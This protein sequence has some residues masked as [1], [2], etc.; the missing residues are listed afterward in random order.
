MGVKWENPCIIGSTR[1]RSGAAE[2]NSP[3]VVQ[4]GG[5][6]ALQHLLPGHATDH[7]DT[8]GHHPAQPADRLGPL[9]KPG[10][11]TRQGAGQVWD[12]AQLHLSPSWRRLSLTRLSLVAS[13]VVCV[14]RAQLLL[15]P[16]QRPLLCSPAQ[17][18][19]GRH[20]GKRELEMNTKLWPWIV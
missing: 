9:A 15:L 14:V 10:R 1:F 2:G 20:W 4:S 6:A 12:A 5:G 11:P 18:A 8:A 7:A 3:G 16:P 13:Q 17:K 19:A